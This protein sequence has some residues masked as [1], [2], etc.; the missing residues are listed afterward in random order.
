MA[1]SGDP[2]IDTGTMVKLT[3]EQR[4]RQRRIIIGSIRE[5]I[6]SLPE[7]RRPV[8]FRRGSYLIL[9]YGIYQRRHD[10]RG[11]WIELHNWGVEG[12]LQKVEK[13]AEG[14]RESLSAVERHA[15]NGCLLCVKALRRQLTNL[16]SRD[17]RAKLADTLT[18]EMFHTLV[19]LGRRIEQL[20]NVLP[21]QGRARTGL[22]KAV[23]NRH[24]AQGNA[25]TEDELRLRYQAVQAELSAQAN[26]GES[27]SKEQAYR[28]IAPQFDVDAQ[29]I[30][31]SYL[32]WA[33]RIG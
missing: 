31:K 16:D 9:D 22:R 2:V 17:D 8:V 25:L 20:E 33:R 12:T 15:A 10:L 3:R 19:G 14:Y 24:I 27:I 6:Q 29:A 5:E 30:K 7:D 13:L 18:A 4:R 21:L 32:N 28:T 11:F 1:Q 23:R 26:R